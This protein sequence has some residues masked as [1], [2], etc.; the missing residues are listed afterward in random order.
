MLVTR[1]TKTVE[2]ERQEFKIDVVLFH[3]GEKHFNGD[4][5]HKVTVKSLRNDSYNV[6]YDVNSKLELE[7]ELDKIEHKIYTDL[8][9]REEKSKLS[10]EEITLDKL[11]YE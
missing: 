2:F 7:Y 4:K 5:F 10:K 9:K 8:K 11:G 3:H 6:E 1:K